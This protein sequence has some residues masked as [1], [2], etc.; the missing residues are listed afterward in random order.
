MQTNKKSFLKNIVGFS[1][2]TWVSFLLAFIASP[3]A[4]RVFLPEELGK[5]NLFFTYSGL[6]VSFCYIGL[7]QAYV[8]F[9]KEPPLPL[10]TKGL[11]SFCTYIAVGVAIFISV[12]FLLF[13][14]PLSKEIMGE[15]EPTIIYCLGI[16]CISLVVLRFISL[17]YRMQQNAVLY[18]IQGIV[19]AFLTKMAYVVVG[20]MQPNA[21]FSIILLTICLALFTIAC[22]AFQRKNFTFKL[23]KEITPTVKRTIFYFALPLAPLAIFS[24]FTNSA[25]QLVLNQLMGK[26]AIG[27]YSAA[28]GLA[29]TVNII[30]SGFNAYW[31]PYVLENYK[32]N[33]KTRFY[34]VH[35]I[36]ACLLCLFGLGLALFQEVLY[37]IIGENFRSSML[38]FPFLLFSPICYCLSETTC[39]GINISKKTYWTTIIFLI[40]GITNIVCCYLFIPTFGMVGAAFASTITAILTLILRSV[41]GLYYYRAIPSYIYIVYTVVL[42]LASSFT[43][44]FFDGITKYS[45]I[46]GLL[47]I[48]FVL[49]RKEILQLWQLLKELLLQFLGKKKGN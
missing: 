27:I 22:I 20:L 39:M 4:T 1:M 2:M 8:R 36:M 37:L 6:F 31:A 25:T 32:N 44:L 11:F 45:I 14:N 12:L 38:F 34:S 9:F 3:I 16:Y 21:Y 33:Q 42:L 19:Q 49:F 29:S 41:I 23:K 24:Y 10:S 47:V 15:V 7:D 28:L 35:K 18:S 30:Q 26:A 17:S 48:F 43:N 13:K 5:I 40:T 46:I